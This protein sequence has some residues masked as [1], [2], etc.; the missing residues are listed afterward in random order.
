MTRGISRAATRAQ[1]IRVVVWALHVRHVSCWRWCK[2]K[3]VG[4]QF[5]ERPRMFRRPVRAGYIVLDMCWRKGDG[6]DGRPRPEIYTTISPVGLRRR[7]HMALALQER[8]RVRTGAAIPVAR[9]GIGRSESAV[10]SH[11]SAVAARV[12]SGS[13]EG[14]KGQTQPATPNTR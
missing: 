8:A 5:A 4:G 10:E 9:C 14:T 2:T 13:Q 11:G 12:C 6:G 3:K 1:G 7:R